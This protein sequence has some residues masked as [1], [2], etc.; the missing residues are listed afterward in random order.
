MLSTGNLRPGL[1]NQTHFSGFLNIMHLLP[2]PFPTTTYQL[3]KVGRNR[4]STWLN[5]WKGDQ[6][7]P[8]EKLGKL[9]TVILWLFHTR[10]AGKGKKEALWMKASRYWSPKHLEYLKFWNINPSSPWTLARRWWWLCITCA[11]KNIMPPNCRQLH[12]ATKYFKL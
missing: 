6:L 1:L 4:K 8:W 11:S 2:L 3:E 5:W 9:D 12:F 10:S 7:S